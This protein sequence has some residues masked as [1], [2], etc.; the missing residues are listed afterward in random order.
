MAHAGRL[1]V[2][3]C[4]ILPHG[5]LELTAVF[6]AGGAGLRLGWTMVD[7]GRVSRAR[8]LAR[9]GL[10]TGVI[11]LGLVAVLAVSGLI[12]GFV[13]PSALPTGVRIAIGATAW[14]GFLG[15]VFTCGRSAAARLPEHV[16][17]RVGDPSQDEQQ[18]GQP[19]EVLRRQWAAV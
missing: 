3:F 8:A 12:E 14:L 13:T 17:G 18:I 11:A 15:Y 16:A 6:V 19:V 4:D 10:E 1:S 5:L 2:F 9:R 7:P